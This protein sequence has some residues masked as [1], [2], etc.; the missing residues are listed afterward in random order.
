MI[1]LLPPQEKKELA[2]KH[3]LKLI[4][5]LGNIAVISLISFILVLFALNFY[6][7][8]YYNYSKVNLL[9]TEKKYKTDEFLFFENYI[10]ENN[11]Q[12]TKLDDFYKKE[13]Q[14]NSLVKEI[15]SI[16]RP[17]AL[18]FLSLSIQKSD[19]GFFKASLAGQAKT[20]ESLLIFK[21]NIEKN[22][23]IKNINFPPNNWTKSK[24]LEFLITFEII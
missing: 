6:I 23:R 22:Q 18:T 16:Q 13:V 15:I 1:N 11:S 17:Q 24:D 4:M 8:I 12:I 10:K 20:R 19:K 14:L 7:L 3:C 21:E 5:V 9:E 2:Q